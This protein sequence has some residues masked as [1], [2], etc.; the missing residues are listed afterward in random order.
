MAGCPNAE[1]VFTR[2]K[3]KEVPRYAHVLE[4]LLTPSSRRVRTVEDFRKG[5]A[6]AHP[7]LSL[8]SK[9]LLISPAI[10]RTALAAAKE[11][12]IRAAPTIVY[13]CRLEAGG[14]KLAGVV[15]ALDPDA[16]PPLG[17]FLP[18]RREGVGARGRSCFS[19]TASRTSRLRERKWCCASSRRRATGL[20]PT[21][22]RRSPW[23]DCC[24]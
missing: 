17:P 21:A 19:T 16:A 15:A 9:T 1:W 2:R 7:Y 24:R 22:W 5:F 13:L 10:A 4:D 12:N 14:R 20:R 18:P 3:G 8:E 11:A 23:P 6:R